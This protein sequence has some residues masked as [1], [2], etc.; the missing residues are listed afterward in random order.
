MSFK[1][2]RKKNQDCEHFFAKI[3]EV[4]EKG[5]DEQKWLLKFTCHPLVPVLEKVHKPASA[6]SATAEGTA[7]SEENCNGRFAL[8]VLTDGFHFRYDIISKR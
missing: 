7:L 5:E 4:T 2:K 6:F 3:A 1:E 8:T